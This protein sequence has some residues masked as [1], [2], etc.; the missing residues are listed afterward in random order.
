ML[1][2]APQLVKQAAVPSPASAGARA[3]QP[4]SGDRSGP[5]P[6]VCLSVPQPSTEPAGSGRDPEMRG[7]LPQRSRAPY[8]RNPGVPAPQIRVS[9]PQ[10]SGCPCPTPPP[11][12]MHNPP[13]FS[14]AFHPHPSLSYQHLSSPASPPSQLISSPTQPPFPRLSQTLPH[15]CPSPELPWWR[16]RWNLGLR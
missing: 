1:F 9:L 14:P 12:Q 2:P 4:H 10:K 3:P 7:S 15:P 8:P 13:S 11:T 6:S 16:L 5:G